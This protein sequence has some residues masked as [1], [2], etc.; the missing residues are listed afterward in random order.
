MALKSIGDAVPVLVFNP[1]KRFIGTF[2]SC[3]AAASAFN[4]SNVTIHMACAGKIMSTHKLYF[5]FWDNPQFTFEDIQNMTLQEW[6]KANGLERKYYPTK[7][8][9]RNGMKYKKHA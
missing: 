6:D 9:T 1:L 5:R 8:M 3:S 7:H 4:I 2:R